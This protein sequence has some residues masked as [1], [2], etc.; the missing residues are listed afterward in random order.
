MFK[1][2]YIYIVTF[3]YN[4]IE[5]RLAFTELDRL[6]IHIVH[7]FGLSFDE[8]KVL[9]ADGNEEIYNQEGIVIEQVVLK[10]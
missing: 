7:G 3:T 6:R 2:D 1:P 4:G 9:K 5:R 8:S 10:R